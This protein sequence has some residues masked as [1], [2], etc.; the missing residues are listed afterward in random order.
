MYWATPAGEKYLQ[1]AEVDHTIVGHNCCPCQ[2]T[3]E[4]ELKVQHWDDDENEAN[5]MSIIPMWELFNTFKPDDRA[6][7]KHCQ[8]KTE[9]M[10]DPDGNLV[11]PKMR[12]DMQS[13]AQARRNRIAAG[14]PLPGD[15]PKDAWSVPGLTPVGQNP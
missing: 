11:F 9:Y 10:Y 8:T 2:Y 12:A 15:T 5:M 14:Q 4:V 13:K 7:L 6:R 1:I 3:K